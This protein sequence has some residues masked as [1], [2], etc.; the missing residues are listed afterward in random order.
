MAVVNVKSLLV[1]NMDAQPRVIS[2]GYM[3]GGNDTTITAVVACGASD[4]AASV[5]RVGFLPSGVLLSDLAVMNDA[6]TAGTSYKFGVAYSTQ[7]TGKP[8]ILPGT[9][10]YST[11]LPV[12]Y[13]DQI[14]ASG[15][16]MASARNIWTPLLNPA[17][18][19]GTG[20]PANVA[21]RVWE[22]LGLAQDPFSL[23]HL[24]MTAV[25]PGTAGGNV[26]VRYNTI[27]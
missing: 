20:A 17:I 4:T 3:S 6:N 23:F 19:S 10:S 15:I 21:L 24:I 27:G 26:A 13:A 5:Y 8:Y 11:T 18:L 9:A 1:S 12:Q 2:S 22:L 7:D 14:F 25:T 16:T